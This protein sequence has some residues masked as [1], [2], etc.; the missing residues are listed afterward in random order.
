MSY[1]L[2][3][4]HWLTLICLGLHLQGCAGKGV[5]GPPETLLQK[6]TPAAAVQELTGLV[7]KGPVQGSTVT[8]FLLE[9]GKKGA[10]LA[11]GLTDATGRFLLKIPG[12]ARSFFIEAEGGAYQDEATGLSKTLVKTMCSVVPSHSP[13]QPTMVTPLTHLATSILETNDTI[14]AATMQSSLDKV[15]SFFSL[16]DIL[17][18]TP[19]TEPSTAN[20][21]E[22][23]H[24]R[25]YGLILA[26]ISEMGK[27]INTDPSI[28]MEVLSQDIS[29]GVLDGKQKGTVLVLGKNE[30][31]AD[32]GTTTLAQ[33]I[34]DF[35][36]S[37]QN[38]SSARADPGF[39][40]NLK[41][42]DGVIENPQIS[43]SLLP[44]PQLTHANQLM[45]KGF[46]IPGGVTVSGF[47]EDGQ[48]AKLI[49]GFDGSFS[50][51]LPLQSNA[52]NQLRIEVSNGFSQSQKR[53]SVREDSQAPQILLT[54]SPEGSFKTSSILIPYSLSDEF[55][56]PSALTVTINTGTMSITTQSVLLENLGQGK[57]SL[58]LE[59]RD[60]LGNSTQVS[61]LLNIDLSPPQLTSALPSFTRTNLE[62]SLSFSESL[63]QVYWKFFPSST[64]TS[65][66]MTFNPELTPQIALDFQNIQGEHRL[67]INASDAAGN[68]LS[69]STG[70]IFDSLAP[71]F[72]SSPILPWVTRSLQFQLPFQAE[73]D[74]QISLTLTAPDSSMSLTTSATSFLDFQFSPVEGFWSVELL[75]EDLA[76]NQTRIQ[77]EV[78]LDTI[79]PDA[80]SLS[81]EILSTSATTVRIQVAG[82]SGTEIYLDGQPT[83]ILLSSTSTA[84]PVTPSPNALRSFALTLSDAAGNIS[85][86]ST[87][88]ITH[89]NLSPAG[90]LLVSNPSG[91]YLT[92]GNSLGF[93][94]TLSQPESDISAE[95]KFLENIYG[96]VS[97]DNLS[98]TTSFKLSGF[99]TDV[100]NPPFTLRAWDALLNSTTIS[101]FLTQTLDTIAPAIQSV[102][103]SDLST[104]IGLTRSASVNLTLSKT[105]LG[106]TSQARFL[107]LDLGLTSTDS[108]H[109]SKVFSPEVTHPQSFPDLFF[110]DFSFSDP[111]GNT[112]T[113]RSTAPFATD[114]APPL[115]SLLSNNQESSGFLKTSDS[116]LFTLSLSSIEPFLQISATYNTTPL[117]FS[118]QGIGSF[119]E[120]RYTLQSS[121]PVFNGATPLIAVLSVSDAAGNTANLSALTTATGLL[122]PVGKIFDNSAPQV[123]RTSLGYSR[124]AVLIPG[125]SIGIEVWLTDTSGSP[126]FGTTPLSLTGTLNSETLS[127]IQSSS[128]SFQFSAT[129]PI[130]HDTPANA[131]A[132]E[133]RLQAHDGA[134][135]LSTL[136]SMA[137]S[138]PIDTQFTA[139]S[140]VEIS[141]NSTSP[142]KISSDQLIFSF[143][144]SST[145]DLLAISATAKT[146]KTTTSL[147]FLQGSNS[148]LYTATSSIIASPLFTTEISLNNVI[149]QRSSGSLSKPRSYVLT[150]FH[151]SSGLTAPMLIDT[152]RPETDRIDF[153]SFD[154][155]LGIQE[156]VTFTIF[157]TYGDLSSISTT[158]SLPLTNLQLSLS[159]NGISL[160]PIL[161]AS[162]QSYS[163]TYTLEATHSSQSTPLALTGVF[164]TDAEG[165]LGS[166]ASTAVN[167]T[168]DPT[169]PQPDLTSLQV[170]LTPIANPLK[171]GDS[172]EFTLRPSSISTAI[173]LS[174]SFNSTNLSFSSTDSIH[175]KATYIIEDGAQDRLSSANPPQISNIQF[176]DSA[177][178]LGSLTS[179]VSL[180]YL[181]DANAP[182]PDSIEFSPA[183]TDTLAVGEVVSFSV[184]LIGDPDPTLSV[185]GVFRGSPLTF[186]SSFG[187]ARFSTSYTI[188]T[189]PTLFSTGEQLILTLTDSAGNSTTTSTTS[190]LI[191]VDSDPP[192]VTGVQAI[193]LTQNTSY[194]GI[195]SSILFSVS[196]ST[197]ATAVGL[198]SIQTVTGSFNGSSLNFQKST[199]QSSALWEAIFTLTENNSPESSETPFNLTTP[200][201]QGIQAFDLAG[202]SSAT[203]SDLSSF[204]GSLVTHIF[205]TVRP[206]IQSITATSTTTH[207]TASDLL[208]I[209]L[210]A[211]SI[212]TDLL[213]ASG[214]FNSISLS[215]INTGV[216][217]SYHSTYTVLTT[218]TNQ[219]D[220]SNPPQISAFLTDFAGNTSPSFVTTSLSFLIITTDIQ[221]PI[222]MSASSLAILTPGIEPNPGQFLKLGDSLQFSV[223]ASSASTDINVLTA[224]YNGVLLSFAST[225]TLNWITTYTLS[226]GHPSQSSTLQLT[227]ILAHDSAG[228]ISNPTATT[229]VDRILDTTAPAILSLIV[230]SVGNLSVLTVGQSLKFQLTPAL[231]YGSVETGG[232]V[233]GSYNLV[234]LTWIEEPSSGAIYSATYTA[235]VTHNDQSTPLQITNVI[236][237]DQ[238]GNPSPFASS[239]AALDGV[240]VT[241][242]TS[243]PNSPSVSP[244]RLATNTATT[245][246]SVAGEVGT[247][248]YLNSAFHSLVNSS[249]TTTV[250]VSLTNLTI[251]S[252]SFHIVDESGNQSQPS[253]AEVYRSSQARM[254]LLT[255]SFSGLKTT[256][257]N[258]QFIAESDHDPGTFFLASRA[259]F[260]ELDFNGEVYSDLNHGLPYGIVQDFSQHPDAS[261]SSTLILVQ[262]NA[263]FKSEDRGLNW[264]ELASSTFSGKTLRALVFH[265]PAPSN[266]YI[267]TDQNLFKSSDTGQNFTDFNTNGPTPQSTENRDLR[268]LAYDSTNARLYVG[269]L[270]GLYHSNQSGTSWSDLQ[271]DSADILSLS[272]PPSQSETLFLISTSAFLRTTNLLTNSGL[273]GFD[274]ITPQAGISGGDVKAMTLT[275]QAGRI[276]IATQNGVFESSDQGSTWS[277]PQATGTGF[278]G[279][280][281]TVIASDSTNPNRL[282]LGNDRALSKIL[283]N[284][285]SPYT[286]NDLTGILPPAISSLAIPLSDTTSFFAITEMWIY[287][288]TQASNAWNLISA[289]T[290]VTTFTFAKPLRGKEVLFIGSRE[291]GL[292]TMSYSGTDITTLSL[293][294]NNPVTHITSIV[295]HPFVTDIV[296]VGTET[297]GLHYSTDQ[298]GSWTTSVNGL[299]I[300]TILNLAVSPDGS[301]VFLATT[302]SVLK[303]SDL[304]NPASFAWTSL[305]ACA[306][307]SSVTSLEVVSNT[308]GIYLVATGDLFQGSND[309]TTL[310]NLTS[311]LSPTV[312]SA[313]I[314]TLPS[315]STRILYLGTDKGLYKSEDDGGTFSLMPGSILSPILDILLIGDTSKHHKL[316][317]GT[318]AGGY[319][320]EDIK[321]D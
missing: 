22:S 197:G 115:I 140:S 278:S 298:G 122:T 217:G 212:T 70:I 99:Q 156:S 26:G 226:S 58:T 221:A 173:S 146:G 170:S 93:S 250:L 215:F 17:H 23:S 164:F 151:L 317:L 253:T 1:K 113:Q 201:I 69:T 243:I 193:A 62:L 120:G 8:V 299:G 5:P 141:S 194:L 279:P 158:P 307:Q 270:A 25:Q 123:E 245:V 109:F 276:F 20:T 31:Q 232:F 262:K 165:R 283:N 73:L 209:T 313:R 277:T 188:P 301:E 302:T 171:I 44:I 183:F 68:P 268:A 34:E 119:Y 116:V 89:D 260:G 27:N 131:L 216:L 314:M 295:F 273:P 168:L 80:P 78:L 306:N 114:T 59:S 138:F 111:A 229:D 264:S 48:I 254:Q 192:A 214:V 282:L 258:L 143:R 52:I 145:P 39:L 296:L 76:G 261:Q 117:T 178:N 189:S 271:T 37:S 96:L 255:S 134:G 16:P 292:S 83:G 293:D 184:D 172:L 263:L 207:L 121:H 308:N 159:Y 198:D 320:I 280:D 71:Q 244:L 177:G 257:L 82:E 149:F 220:A 246:L 303:A 202:N 64:L 128:N 225:D 42:S 95:I 12:S 297:F 53:F 191:S 67:E 286:V 182:R 162:G 10:L 74:S 126:L 310:T 169:P 36:E 98:F 137:T 91:T 51:A 231:N 211:S 49:T 288:Y 163:A 11:Q 79:A 275:T 154:P 136:F 92:A 247:S 103:F 118:R 315:T 41:A 218:N 180:T 129:Y 285:A 43:F 4:F 13:S 18:T 241:I 30:V 284:T 84:L 94:F 63:S 272:I 238:A 65:S 203:I 300:Q 223:L 195:G 33:A 186:I 77:T 75:L 50:L 90:N 204:P 228:N 150:A 86:A 101:S 236:F 175:F 199:T 32:L 187:G 181:I 135:N 289:Q 252:F 266:V 210:N 56:L 233:S 281:Y 57:H 127:F 148:F 294:I 190:M 235:L 81:P 47:N 45:V 304:S 104:Q 166:P 152:L 46:T 167:F 321:P 97:T 179:S 133:L 160:S 24:A 66:V 274:E 208:E 311:N 6:E 305:G 196:L 312:L 61:F 100:V 107:S 259:G 227:K 251:T 248:L 2:K 239:V 153:T 130:D 105:E 290:P 110:L 87:L 142:R 219:S 124:S 144:F 249:G 28:I 269:T 55:G 265:P 108:R 200:Q 234:P 222:L 19:L 88:S 3:A 112:T 38:K 256:N 9:K 40:T 319:I 157:P 240:T 185:L 309:C 267:A 85:Q 174:G 21:P 15:A 316:F 60:Q 237:F 54:S 224:S 139:P 72:L 155:E 132:P 206:K 205:D 213:Q 230:T 29:D 106:V 318:Q 125:D 161:D 291:T 287:R 176:K 147:I 7:S 242:D 35:S 102:F 14:T